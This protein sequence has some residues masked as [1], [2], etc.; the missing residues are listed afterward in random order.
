MRALICRELGSMDK[1][2]IEDFPDPAPT[3][4]EGAYGALAEC[5][6]AGQVV[7]ERVS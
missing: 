4:T 7:L 6:A 2:V 1:G 3:A 5:W